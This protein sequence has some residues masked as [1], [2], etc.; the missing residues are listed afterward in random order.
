MLILFA[1][2]A[3]KGAQLVRET[4]RRQLGQGIKNVAN[5]VAKTVANQ[6]LC[7][8]KWPVGSIYGWLGNFLNIINNLLTAYH[9]S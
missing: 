4:H 9:P 8:M 5:N 7:Q 2:R 1:D 6:K 3:H